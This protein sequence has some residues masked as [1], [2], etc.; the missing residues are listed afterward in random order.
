VSKVI[1]WKKLQCFLFI[2][3]LFVCGSI[4]A[5]VCLI[6][7]VV[8]CVWFL[9]GQSSWLQIQR[10]WVDSLH[11]QIFWKV[12]GL[13]QG[14]L[15]LMGT[16]KEMLGRK[17]SCSG[18]EYREYSIGIR[19]ATHNTLCP[20]NLALTSPTSCS[21]LVCIVCSRTEAA[22]FVVVCYS[23]M[24]MHIHVQHCWGISTWSELTTLFTDLILFW[25]SAT[26]LH[27]RRTGWDHSASSVMR[28]WWKVSK[29]YWAH[30]WH[31]SLTQAFKNLIAWYEKYLS[32][33]SDYIENYL[34]YVPIFYI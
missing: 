11:Y 15:S 31:T 29:H 33:G 8:F 22:E 17:S 28:S 4:F 34:N 13:E 25:A 14:P 21:C 26:C 19:Y 27:A 12:M 23:S 6:P 16:I 10:F 18:L 20:Q 2:V 32:S 5:L 3:C 1:V 7:R 30:R 9:C 24:T